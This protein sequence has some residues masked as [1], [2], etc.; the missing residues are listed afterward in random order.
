MRIAVTTLALGLAVLAAGCVPSFHPLYTEEDLVL[1]D[2]LVGLW[3]QDDDEDKWIFERSEGKAYRLIQIDD[4]GVGRL[5]V[6]IV[7]LG[8]HRFLDTFPA[9]SDG[10]QNVMAAL[11]SLPV[12]TLWKLTVEEDAVSMAVMNPTWLKEGIEKGTLQVK[13]EMLRVADDSGV[14]LTA[15]TAELQAFVL[16]HADEED[17]WGGPIKLKRI[18]HDS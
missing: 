7:Q 3:G 17:A 14:V 9:E 18:L 15:S 2:R 12:H 4:N 6:H 13:H 10:S 16:K 8:E 5:D 11:H 1:D